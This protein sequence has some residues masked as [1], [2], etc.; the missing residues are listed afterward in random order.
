[1]TKT[2][3]DARPVAR[4][5]LH[6]IAQHKLDRRERR[7]LET[8]ETLYRVAMDLFAKHGFV[9]TTTEDITEAADVGQG[10]FFNYF[11]TKAHVLLAF[12]EKQMA[13]GLAALQEAESGKI[14]IR[15]VLRR[16]THN[17]VEELVRTQA[18]TRSLLTIFVAQDDVRG[19]MRDTL[20]LVRERLA[21]I[22]VIGQQ[23]GEIR[24]DRKPAELAAALQRNVL[25][26]LLLWAVQPK[27]DPDEWLEKAFR[28]FWEI[29]RVKNR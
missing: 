20:A 21:R 6:R 8:R 28:D 14:P 3:E 10:T 5:K 7:S 2:A 12:S 27:S 1:M 15:E 9:E 23:R 29:A 24:R 4:T 18:L 13:K 16:F 11:P 17:I 26:T 19:I 22:C 25:G